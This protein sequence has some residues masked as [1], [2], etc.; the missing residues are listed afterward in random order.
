MLTTLK[1]YFEGLIAIVNE[2]N[3]NYQELNPF[4]YG[5]GGM[6]VPPTG[7]SYAASKLFAVGR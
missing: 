3:N 1:Q 6:M 7:F 4:E 2:T 5:G